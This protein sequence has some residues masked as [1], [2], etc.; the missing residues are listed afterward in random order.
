MRRQLRENSIRIAKGA[1]IILQHKP[2]SLLSPSTRPVA[3]KKFAFDLL[4]LDNFSG[5]NWNRERGDP[6]EMQGLKCAG[7]LDADSSG[8][9]LW[10][11][12]AALVDYIISPHTRVEKEYLVRIKNH[13]QWT[14][15]QLDESLEIMRQGGL[16]IE[17]GSEPLRPIP[18]I[19][20]L[21]EAQLQIV[22]KEGQHRQI[23]K[24]CNLLGL[25]VEALKRVRIGQ[26]RLGGLSIGYWSALNP[27]QAASL[28]LPSK[29]KARQDD[30]AVKSA[31]LRWRS[32]ALEHP[33]RV[34][35]PTRSRSKPTTPEELD[36]F[37][38]ALRG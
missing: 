19:R 37:R 29:K 23:R 3:N 28:L 13:E 24:M 25:E 38:Q 30:A 9:L 6:R 15:R 22:L 2:F 17:E 4:T 10:T 14:A 21:N 35:T 27:K 20:Q 11:D 34:E 33:G 16:V 32:D 36:A 26:A 31:P 8:L 7:R 1:T 5:R 12:D 18:L